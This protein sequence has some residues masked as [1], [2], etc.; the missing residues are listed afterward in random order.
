M[1]GLVPAI[2]AE[3][4]AR[5]APTTR[6]YNSERIWLDLFRSPTAGRFARRRGRGARLPVTV[7]SGF[8]GAG[9]TM[10]VRHFLGTPQGPGAAVEQN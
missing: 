6:F 7:V 2:Y 8:L 4:K 5:D 3:L 10:L 9:K 1:A